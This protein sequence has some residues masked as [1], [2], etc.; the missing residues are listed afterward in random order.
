VNGKENVNEPQSEENSE[1][2]AQANLEQGVPTPVEPVSA[3]LE[4]A[5]EKYCIELEPYQ[6]EMLKD[7]CQ[8]LWDWNENLN[9]TRHTDFD[10]FVSRDI[11]DTIQL[12]DL[13]ETGIEVLDFG[14]GGG[15][16]GIPL[17]ILRPDLQVS[18]CESVGKKAAVLDDM[19]TK[20]SLPIPVINARVEDL[21]ND[22]N[23][24]VLVCRAVGP[25]WKMGLW[26]TPYWHLFGQLLAIKGPAWTEERKAARHR[27]T[28]QNVELRKLKSYPMIG[29]D[30][31]SV[32]LKMWSSHKAE[33][34]HAT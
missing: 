13:I 29:T 8:L 20:L 26:L 23:Y 25:L 7:Y 34:P 3:T 31:E 9:L 6:I 16:P 18:L 4:E 19:I 33:P 15:V 11:L 21:L 27:G 32:I 28:L 1:V 5:L 2:D 14:S 22:L 17:A 10:R 30:S 24:D 12:A